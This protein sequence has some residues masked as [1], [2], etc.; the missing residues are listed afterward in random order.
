MADK[1]RELIIEKALQRFAHFGIQKTTMNEIAEDLS[2]SKPSVYYYFPDKTSLTIAVIEWIIK[3]YHERLSLLFEGSKDMSESVIAMLEL[4]I[5]F[6]ERYFMLHLEDNTE[7]SLCREEVKDSIVKIRT[8]EIALVANLF[9]KGIQA[10]ELNLQDSSHTAELFINM[11]SGIAMWVLGEQKKQ[12]IPDMESFR[13]V[14]IKQKELAEIFLKG[15]G[16]V[17]NQP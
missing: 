4:R 11:L 8:N 2:M 16:P 9:D 6:L 3:E 14:F 7:Q 17:L 15:I 5:E 13:S 12:L 10:G 1:K